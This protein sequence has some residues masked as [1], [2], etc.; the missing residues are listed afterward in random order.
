MAHKLD[1]LSRLGFTKVEDLNPPYMAINMLEK[2]YDAASVEP[3]IA[4]TWD[5]AEAFKAGA[6]AKEGAETY[7]IVIPPPNVTGSLHMGHA[8]N[9]T[10]Q[11]VLVRFERMRGK[12]V[13]WQPGMDHAGIATQMVVER[14]LAESGGNETRRQMGRE[15]FIQK[16]W[17]WKEESGGTIFNQLKRLGAS[18]DWSRE[19]FT[20]DEGL[21]KAVLEVFVTLYN[22]GLI[23]RGKRLVNWDPKFETA[24]SDLEVEN[25]EVDGHMWHFKYPLADGETY[26]YVE[27]DAD[28]NVTLKEI[29][30]Y[31]SIATTRPETML[32]DG[33]VAVHMSDER[34]ASIV[35]K[36]CEIP[37][38]PKEH[39]RFIPIITDEYP[40]KD[41]GSGAVKITG[42]HDFNDYQVAKRND[43][44]LY[45]LMDVTA[46]MRG[47][48][49]PY[50][51]C[52][53][54]AMALVKAGGTPDENYV[55]S[56][57]LVPDEYRGLDRLEARV[58]VIADVTAEGL[59]VMTKDEEGNAIPLVENNKMMQPFGDRSNVVIE[60]MLTD[61]WFADAKTMAQPA[62]ASVKEG[63]TKFVPK[64]WENTYF[65]WME[66]IQPWCIS[67]QLWWGHQIPAWYGPDKKWLKGNLDVRDGTVFKQPDIVFVAKCEVDALKQ[68]QDYYGNEVSI[69][70][71]E[72]QGGGVSGDSV[73]QVTLKRDNDVLDTWFSSAL[74]PFSTMGWP[75]QTPELARYYQTDVLVTGFDIIFF[76]VARM[77]MSGLH[78][79]KD[80]NGKGIEPFHT[81]Y[82]HALVRDKHGAKMSKSKGN[83]IDPLD[84][85]DEYGAD[86]L[87]FTLAV[88][89]AQGRDVKLDPQRIE[90]YRNFGTKLWNATRFAEM[91]GAALDTSFKPENA[92][93]QV[94]RWILNELSN[95]IADVTKHI[96]TYRFNDAAGGLY[97][98]TWNLVCDWYL[99][100][101]KPVFQGDDEEAKAE[102]RA[103]VAYI[104]NAIYRLLH[105]FMPYM[106]EELWSVSEAGQASEGL[107]CHA[108]WPTVA[109]QD[110]NAAVEI[111][112]LIDLITGLRSVRSEMNVPP[113][114][115][116]P[117]HVTGAN[118]ATREQLLR[119]LPAI[120][121]LARVEDI[122]LD[123][124]VTKGAA[125][126]VVSETTYSLPLGA[127]IDLDAEKARLEKAIGKV[128]GDL[129]KVSGKLANERF[130]ANARPDVVAAERERLT[131]LEGQKAKLN[132]ALNRVLEAE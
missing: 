91:N 110:D 7:S 108:A 70:V 2:T 64:T 53:A 62:L 101:L 57:N 12:D 54:Q 88:M 92:K 111:N 119:H 77:M 109:L 31:I 48:G 106:T 107:L 26:E 79:M 49:A 72:F 120:K 125:Q 45:R 60:P 118:D 18:C 89:A 61:Q 38:G 95:T 80:E 41:F 84:L 22:E 78:F 82:V 9:N 129:Q 98:F 115:K 76:W 44:P 40:D 29:R 37:V 126:I 104:L 42:A 28:G 130:V 19:R 117:L 102:A 50:A 103:C 96:E 97:K 71:G 122:V 63:R 3:K 69:D 66:N 124:E 121:L 56:I 128:D 94:N 1:L 59:A 112:W 116:A 21:S 85:I 16:V 34:Y 8:L 14:K 4:K 74:W 105:P 32:G 20:M 127:L 123:G 17:E 73:N 13:L 131:E 39:R 6:G 67:R 52:S 51:E 27:K 43:I 11:D 5:D 35:G 10:L 23:Y 100:L 68:A 81:V 30:D 58:R 93:L 113:S 36:L 24:I 132:E 25:V 47:D 83:V 55:D 75:D 65:N 46:A 86:A 15:K 90:G 114:S 87:R 99:E 33:A